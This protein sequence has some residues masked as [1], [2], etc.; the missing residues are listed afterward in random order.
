MAARAPQLAAGGSEN[1]FFE[2][3]ED[4]PTSS[5]QESDSDEVVVSFRKHKLFCCCT[6]FS[7]TLCGVLVLLVA[8]LAW[9]AKGLVAIGTFNAI[10]PHLTPKQFP[11]YSS[12]GGCREGNKTNEEI[13]KCIKPCYNLSFV[14]E[15]ER[16]NAEYG[17]ELVYFP[18]RPGPQGEPSVNISAWW[19]PA[20]PTA[21]GPAPRIVVLHGVGSNNN[22]CGV[23]ATCFLL[24]SIGFSCLTPSAR[25]NG[26][27]GSS[28]HPEIT[29]WAYDY[30]LDALGAWD[31]AVEDPDGVLGGPLPPSK[32]G[33]M[34]FSKGALET[35]IAFGIEQRAPGAWLDSGPY[36]GLFGMIQSVLSQ[37]IGRR[38]GDFLARIVFFWAKIF[39]GNRVDVLKPLVLLHNCTPGNVRNVLIAQSTLDAVVPIK[40]AGIAISTLSGL[41]SCYS[42]RTFTPPQYCNGATHHQEMWEFPDDTRRKLCDFW[43]STFKQDAA[44]CNLE[45]QPDFQTWSPET[46]LPPGSPPTPI[47]N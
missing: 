12:C 4:S 8:I 32:V 21:R 1:Q 11:R 31:Y 36:G 14:L 19:L 45:N 29:S 18:S 3:V 5:D 43:S 33:L 23:Q 28:T 44:L 34:G 16:F 37:G 6:I 15:W 41:P 38:L 24:R 25:D 42:V 22:H 39:T 27:S 7:S 17:Y 9:Q 47:L 13:E 2:K 10:D 46:P 26:L 35:A 20:P 30:H 40:Y